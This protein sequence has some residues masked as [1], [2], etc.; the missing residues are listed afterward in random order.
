VVISIIALLIALLLPAL[1][2]ANEVANSAVCRSNLKQIATAIF[3]YAADN[4]NRIVPGEYH[5]N[6]LAG[7]WSTILVED[8]YLQAPT[9]EVDI[10]LAKG[11]NIFRCPSGVAEVSWANGG[12]YSDE[13]AQAWPNYSKRTGDDYYINN[14]YAANGDAD[15]S[16]GQPFV[17]IKLP[18]GPTTYATMDR[19]IEPSRGVG[20][21]DGWYMMK[22]WAI[23]DRFSARH[24]GRT[25]TNIM[26]MDGHVAG[27]DASLLTTLVWGA[28]QSGDPLWQCYDPQ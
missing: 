26:F 28:E 23:H 6:G 11:A 5:D 4:G 22:N 16:I 2:S 12:P 21:A 19:L 25:M 3:N 18:S 14:W 9:V 1:G 24:M 8:E 17:G 20:I 10:E 7:W 13:N 15:L 27:E